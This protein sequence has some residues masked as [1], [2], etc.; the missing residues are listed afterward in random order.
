[1]CLGVELSLKCM[2]W[3]SLS[4]KIEIEIEISLCLQRH[5]CQSCKLCNNSCS[6]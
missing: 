1:M 3:R 4:I 6:C 2:T 5:M